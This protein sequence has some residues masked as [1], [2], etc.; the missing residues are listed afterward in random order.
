MSPVKVDALVAQEA[1]MYP[2]VSQNEGQMRK[3]EYKSKL[4]NMM[5]HAFPA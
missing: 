3:E 1:E 2:T 5:T 4:N